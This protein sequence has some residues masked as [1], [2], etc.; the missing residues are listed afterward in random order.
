MTYLGN[1]L[2]A[3]ARAFYRR[4]RV[5]TIEPAAES[6]LDMSGRVVMTTKYCLRKELGLCPGRGR[7]TGAEPMIL[8][9]QEGRQYPIRFRCGDCGMD[10]SVS[11]GKEIR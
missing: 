1:V 9:D 11:N 8:E 4:H 5:E 6:G 10:I 3:K 2:N 7:G